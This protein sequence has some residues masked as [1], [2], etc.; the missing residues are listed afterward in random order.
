M[1]LFKTIMLAAMAVSLFMFASCS[2][3]GGEDD[4]YFDLENERTSTQEV[5]DDT[6]LDNSDDNSDTEN[7]ETNNDDGTSSSNDEDSSSKEDSSNDENEEPSTQEVT[8]PTIVNP[9]AGN[10]YTCPD[11]TR[12]SYTIT[13]EDS[14][15]NVS[16][17]TYSTTV[18]CYYEMTRETSTTGTLTL[19]GKT[20]KDKACLYI[21][22]ASYGFG[23]DWIYEI[24][25]DGDIV[26][27]T[28]NGKTFIFTKVET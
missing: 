15:C 28:C 22:K 25:N 24:Q 20:Q 21:L 4:D 13:L 12:Y 17:T 1:K 19:V 6:Q 7:A 18:T 27:L 3:S 11:G 23:T 5:T 14:E 26:N 2:T 10:T 9:F 16:Y 8:E